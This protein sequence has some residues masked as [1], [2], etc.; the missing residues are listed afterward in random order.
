MSIFFAEIT[1]IFDNQKKEIDFTKVNN[2][3]KDKTFTFDK[4]NQN[5]KTNCFLSY[6]E[7]KNFELLFDLYESIWIKEWE[8]NSY[9]N[10]E[11]FYINEADLESSYEVIIIFPDLKIISK[12]KWKQN[13]KNIIKNYKHKYNQL[14]PKLF[15]KIF[16]EK[17]KIK[18]KD[19]SKYL[20]LI[21]D[22]IDYKSISEMNINF[23]IFENKIDC[24]N[25]EQGLLGTCYFLAAIS[26]ISNYGQLLYQLFPKEKINP[27]GFYE[28]CL[29]H[30]GRWVKVL[31]D[32]YFPFIKN[33]NKFLWAHPI[34]NCLYSCFL[35]KAYA[36]INGSYN[37]INGGYLSPAFEALTGFECFEVKKREKILSVEK[38]YDIKD[39]VY[40]YFYKKIRDGYLFSCQTW[41]H[42]YSLISLRKENKE[43]IF[44]VRNPWNC[45]KYINDGTFGLISYNKAEYEKKFN[46]TAICPILFNTSIFFYELNKIAKRENHK[47]YLFFQ[48]YKNTKISAGLTNIGLNEGIKIKLKDMNKN[49]E[50]ILITLSEIKKKVSEILKNFSSNDFDNYTDI[51]ISKYLLKIDLSNISNETLKKERLK[52]IIGGNVNIKYLGYLPYEPNIDSKEI[53]IEH[54]KYN[55]GVKTGE[56]FEKYKNTIKLLEEEFSIEMHPDA[57]GYYIETIFTNE[58]ETIVRFDKEKLKNQ[59]CSYDKKEDVY[60][61]GN[62]HIEGKIE[63][64]GKTIIIQD[65]KNINIYKGKIHKNKICCQLLNLNEQSDKAILKIPNITIFN[66]KSA[67]ESK[68]HKHKL[69]YSCVKSSWKCNF[70][71]KLFDENTYSFG[72]RECNFDLCI[73]CLFDPNNQKKFQNSFKEKLAGKINLI[74]SNHENRLKRVEEI[75]LKR[76][77]IAE[78]MYVIKPMSDINKVIQIDNNNNN[79]LIVWDFNNENNQKFNINFNSSSRYYTIQNVES[80]QYLTC[81]ES[82]IY[83][84]LKNNQVN[85]QWL[86]G[87]NSN[88]GYE[89]ILEKNKKYIQVEENANNGVIVSCQEKTGKPNQIFI[90]EATTKTIPPPP[91]IKKEEVPIP[92]VRF[93][94]RPNWH[95]PYIN[96]VSIVDALASVGYPY[97]KNY[98]AQIGNRN[99]IPGV[100]FSPEYNTHM[101]NL[102]KEGRLIIP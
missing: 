4:D 33:T 48:T 90:F 49:N 40:E 18:Y 102:M 37:D 72:C 16:E 38:T 98:R 14:V 70:C 19:K 47:M 55:Y 62:N 5:P 71:S 25:I 57:K 23:K 6:N 65:N 85:Q 96:Q 68:F 39:E 87:K 82:T 94:P 92:I 97:D 36:K 75:L 44:K 73:K 29:Y 41:G 22:I 56:I 12:E 67:I 77:N 2:H 52:I 53:E 42:A 32:D 21:D 78:G 20:K 84:T 101:L 3:Y 91:Q 99:N 69:I 64:E 86:I 15:K 26:T 35:E 50:I 34:N 31:V 60:F 95:G 83:F 11:D 51:G 46:K 81:D 27:E 80:N 30:K 45:E 43:I 76:R 58:V 10:C 100:P 79:N 8:N 7:E 61:L 13:W 88:G 66:E 28:I 89:I 54:K 74:A 17:L 1:E 93:F 24:T 9:N 63:G 59:I